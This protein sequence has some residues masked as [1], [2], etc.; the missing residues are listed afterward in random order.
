M[1]SVE[2]A[3]ECCG[4]NVTRILWGIR[5]GLIQKDRCPNDFK[6]IY[7]IDGTDPEGQMFQ[8]ISKCDKMKRAGYTTV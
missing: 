5:E 3:K 8:M 6:N 7:I 1:D 2:N 4:E